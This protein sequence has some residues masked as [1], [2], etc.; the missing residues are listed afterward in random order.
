MFML[1]YADLN[2]FMAQ[3]WNSFIDIVYREDLRD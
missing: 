3:A 1:T 2:I